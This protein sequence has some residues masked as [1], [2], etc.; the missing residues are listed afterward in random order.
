MFKFRESIQPISPYVPGRPIDDV[1]REFGLDDVVKLAS[2][3]NPYGASPAVRDAVLKTFES[4]A[5]YPDGYCTNLRAA[6]CKYYNVKPENL[7]FGAGTDEVIAM[8]GKVFIDAGDEAITAQITFPQYAAAVEA[9]GGKIVY[10]PMTDHG[11]NLDALL[12]AITPK[13]KMIFIANPNNPTGTYFS[14]EKQDAFIKKVP[15]DIVVV[16]DEAYQEYVAATDYPDTMKTIQEYPNAI[17]L[18]TFSKVYGISSYRVGF[19]ICHPTIVE[20]LEKIR[21]PFN[22]SSQ[23]QAAA[24]AALTD[25]TFVKE[26]F[27]KNRHVMD[28]FIKA[29]DTIGVYS[30]PSQTNFVLSDV[31][32]DNIELFNKLMTKGYIVRPVPPM[33]TFLRITLGTEEEMDGLFK[34]MKEFLV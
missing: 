29:L 16:F 2:N 33:K 23:A 10:T 12:A 30:V 25:Q 26:S 3:E 20:Q 1:K 14:K 5:I 7:I 9:M 13:T 11:Y 6:V 19:G 22:V 31:K 32:T 18:K 24:E 28:K 34:V 8:L 27:T 17:L 15:K 21:C 4:S